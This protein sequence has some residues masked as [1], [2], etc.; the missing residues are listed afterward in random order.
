MD[1]VLPL[2]HCER[3]ALDRVGGKAVGLWELM[4]RGLPV[5]A[6]FAV[7]T[8]AYREFVR[9]EGLDREI[10]RWVDRA[11]ESVDSQLEASRRIRELFTERRP[12]A[13]LTE[14]VARAYGRLGEPPVA[15][16]SSAVGEDAKTAS[17]AGE[18]ESYLWVSG[19]QEVAASVL[20][21]WASLFSPQALSYFAHLGAHPAE[22]A[23][24][25]VVQH[26]VDA[27]VA[28]VMIT[29]DPVTG[30]PSQ[31]TVEA[32]YGLGLAVVG[33]EVTP[34]RFAVDKVTL[35]VRSTRVGRKTVAYRY[36]PVRGR[37]AAFPVPEEVASQPCLQPQQVQQLA[38]MG[39]QLERELGRAQDVEWAVDSGGRLYLVQTRPETVWSNRPRAPL[40]NPDE[41]MLSRIL[42]SMR[43][44]MRIA[45]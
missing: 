7:T 37:V 35:E 6:G 32:S 27:Q 15:V 45:D 16:R 22:A 19:C 29:L 1:Y 28:G 40:S 24:G 44:P 10:R 18:H 9:S 39:R 11:R 17:F 30:D 26:M 2:E 25:V 14:E 8:H 41:P 23:M 5:P 43:I 36:D 13:F 12:P 21:C 3:S 33:G 4:R 34:D 31:V 42:H 20:R 38:Q